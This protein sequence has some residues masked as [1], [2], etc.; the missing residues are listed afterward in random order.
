MCYLEKS[1]KVQ[2]VPKHVNKLGME[3]NGMEWN[4]MEWNGSALASSE[5]TNYRLT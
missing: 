3:W 1:S 2:R 4:G 5:L